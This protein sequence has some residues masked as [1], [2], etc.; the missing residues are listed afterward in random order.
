MKMNNLKTNIKLKKLI[1]I[2]KAIFIGEEDM[3]IDQ[4]GE[5]DI[6]AQDTVDGD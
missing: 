5:E 1:K 2:N 3:D 4:G 6:M